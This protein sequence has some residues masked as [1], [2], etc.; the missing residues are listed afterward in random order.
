[1]DLWLL[2]PCGKIADLL[3]IF[4]S[5]YFLKHPNSYTNTHFKP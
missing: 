5:P 4:I 2:L 3:H 1:M